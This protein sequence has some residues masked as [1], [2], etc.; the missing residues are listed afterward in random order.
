MSDWLMGMMA[1]VV[2]QMQKTAGVASPAQPDV[3][4]K[5]TGYPSFSPETS[6]QPL[7][8]KPANL[9]T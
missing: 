8:A 3:G 2:A 5:A 1:P 4:A 6:H 9:Q 7:Y